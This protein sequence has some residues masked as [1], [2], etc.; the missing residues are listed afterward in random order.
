MYLQYVALINT[1]MNMSGERIIFTE[2]EVNS[3]LSK[4]NPRKATGPDGLCGKIL[5]ECRIQ[6][7]PVLLKLFQESMDSHVIPIQW[8]TAELVPVPKSNLP[9]GKNDL[10]PIALTAIIMKSFE[11][12]VLKHLSPEDLVDKFQFAYINKR[13]VEDA[14]LTLLHNLQDHLDHPRTFARILFIDFSS[15]FNTIQPHILI[16]KLMDKNVNLNLIL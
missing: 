15:A 7:S 11:R 5:K 9:S 14:T 4:I 8:L 3:A 13:S 10:R 12:I 1:L 6:L 2:A 16:Q